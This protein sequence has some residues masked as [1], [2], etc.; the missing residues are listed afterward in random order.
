MAVS[1]I[2]QRL[3]REVELRTVFEHPTVRGFAPVVAGAR[4]SGAADVVPV[5]RDRPLPLSFAQER[6]WFLDRTSDTGES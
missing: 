2:A 4:V 1:R 3:G 5:D 6:L